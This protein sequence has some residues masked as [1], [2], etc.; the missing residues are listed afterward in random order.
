M[1][2]QQVLLDAIWHPENNNGFDSRGIAIYRRNLLANA[3]RALSISFPTI[4]MLLNSDISQQATSDFL[5]IVPPKQGDWAQW[6]EDF[7]NFLT[8]Q[9]QI[10]QYPYLPD[11]A[12]LDWSIHL[13][14]HGEDNTV[15]QASLQRLADTEPQ[16]IIV[17]FN[18]NVSMI[19]SEYPIVDIYDAHHAEHQLSRKQAMQRAKSALMT[20]NKRTSV[21]IYRPEYQPQA[22]ELKEAEAMFVKHL[23][24]GDSLAFALDQVSGDSKFSFEQWLIT[25]IEHNLILRFKEK[26]HD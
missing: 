9:S 22:R 16:H 2:E 20:S 14:Q 23:L 18:P 11:C 24:A 25:A 19:V 15:D 10:A 8:V 4:F 26:S 6:G 3:T 12:A 5:N 1:S 21:L 17:E 13:A 7:A